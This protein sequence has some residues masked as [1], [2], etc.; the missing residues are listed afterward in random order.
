ME[1]DSFLLDCFMSGQLT[2]R[3]FDRLTTEGAELVLARERLGL[4]APETPEDWERCS[5]AGVPEVLTPE[6]ERHRWLLT[7]A[8]RRVQYGHEHQQTFSGV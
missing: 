5:L 3:G 4:G 1:E 6:V 8:A 7:E 2:V